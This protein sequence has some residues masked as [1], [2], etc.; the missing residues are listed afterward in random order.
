MILGTGIDL[1]DVR[2][3]EHSVTS[4]PRLLQRLF[5]VDERGLKIE[6]LAARFAAKEALMK[7]LGS[8]VGLTFVEVTVRKDEKGKPGFVFEGGTAEVLLY[9]C[10]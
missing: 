1:V 7:A 4:A 10:G 9:R 5:S 6:Q 3:F 2:R 8:P